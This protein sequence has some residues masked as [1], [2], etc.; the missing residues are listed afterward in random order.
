M[1]LKKKREIQC[2][3]CQDARIVS[4]GQWWNIFKKKSSTGNCPKCKE[5]INITGLKKGRGWNKGI[6]GNDSHCFGN[7]HN[8]VLYGKD[9][10]AWKGGITP[11]N[12][13]IR[14]S[15]EYIAWRISIFERDGY[16]CQSCEQVGGKLHVHHIKSFSEF[17]E[18]RFNTNNGVT[19]CVN[20][21]KLTD[22]FAGKS[23]K[24]A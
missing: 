3:K 15:N 23:K 20:C 24:Y 13:K 22:N 21:H 11:K 12:T 7:K 16:K 18:E 19:L 10:P 4:Y 8:N 17:P 14:N 1:G 2:P 6:V 5:G 9:N